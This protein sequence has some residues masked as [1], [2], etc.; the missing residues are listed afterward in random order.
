MVGAA[1][2]GTPKVDKKKINQTSFGST[3]RGMLK[4]L[5]KIKLQ[6]IPSLYAFLYM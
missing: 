2:T 1:Q 3:E 6:V 5:I 4:L